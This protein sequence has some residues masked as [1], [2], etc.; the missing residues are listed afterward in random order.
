MM[1]RMN[2]SAAESLSHNGETVES[3]GDA[4]ENLVPQRLDDSQS[5]R[6]NEIRRLL[7]D[8]MARGPWRIEDRI[9]ALSSL[10]D[11]TDSERG[12][13]HQIYQVCYQAA[14]READENTMWRYQRL[15]RTM[16]LQ[17]TV[18]STGV[19][20]RPDP[21]AGLDSL[22]GFSV[23]TDEPSSSLDE[24]F[25]TQ[26]K[27]PAAKRASPFY[28]ALFPGCLFVGA[29]LAC[30]VNLQPGGV[31]ESRGPSLQSSAVPE[32]SRSLYEPS[33]LQVEESSAATAADKSV[34][35]NKPAGAVAVG[36]DNQAAPISDAPAAPATVPAT[37]GRP[38]NVVTARPPMPK[39]VV[40]T[41]AVE[42]G[43]ADSEAARKET[44]GRR[45]RGPMMPVQDL[46]AQLE[47]LKAQPRQDANAPVNAAESAE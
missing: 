38:V 14:E 11:L 36:N 15:L 45:V 4:T 21:L 34:S 43:H 2:R 1:N 19:H 24:G 27:T 37:A 6:C 31:Y 44:A 32:D 26:S 5:D 30:L 22:A 12:V 10:R 13:I 35:A 7:L 33:E 18:A 9:E 42:A 47:A 20:Q 3:H 41:K 46:E 16:A 39:P 29:L 17:R 40:P 28:D 23:E 8:I 25:P